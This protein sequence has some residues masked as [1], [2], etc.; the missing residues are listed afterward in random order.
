[1]SSMSESDL[2][3]AW[4]VVPLL[5]SEA[6]LQLLL[7]LLPSMTRGREVD[8]DEAVAVGS[9]TFRD[10]W[11]WLA[12]V[13]GGFLSV[14]RSNDLDGLLF[15][16]LD[17]LCWRHSPGAAGLLGEDSSDSSLSSWRTERRRRYLLKSRRG[18]GKEGKSEAA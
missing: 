18:E 10:R 6:S 8:R 7:Q 1:M 4:R 17:D 16:L 13:G 11:C 2:D 9:D 15:F 12:A 14:S 5:W 3:S